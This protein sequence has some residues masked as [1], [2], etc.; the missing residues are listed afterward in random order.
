MAETQKLIEGLQM[1]VTNLSQQ[2]I[3]HKIQARI[4]ASQGFNVLAEKYEEH[5]VEEMGYVSKCIDRILD[6][7]GAVKNECKPEMPTCDN[8]VGWV[9]TDL[10]IS[11][12]GLAQLKGL[13]D[14]AKDDYTT[15]D[16]LVDYYKDEEEDMYWGQAQLELI[17]RIGEQNWLIKQM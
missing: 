9:K 16:I 5:S 4:F 11:I 15:Y 14:L 8:P 12:D 2:S 10:Q 6:L 7:G 17:E 1:I 3:G 13:I